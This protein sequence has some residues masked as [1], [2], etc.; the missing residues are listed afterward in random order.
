MLFKYI[1]NPWKNLLMLILIGLINTILTYDDFELYLL[2]GTLLIN[3]NRLL[4]N[5]F[6][7]SFI[8][9]IIN[10]DFEFK[11]N[12]K[13]YLFWNVEILSVITLGII[14]L[15]LLIFS[16]DLIS[17]YISL[18]LYVLSTYIIILTPRSYNFFNKNPLFK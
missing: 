13:Y 9:I 15:L 3:N 5:I 11:S 1:C 18:E 14:G 7:L 4:L 10:Q 16:I 6:L 2:D 17:L 12:N 8:L